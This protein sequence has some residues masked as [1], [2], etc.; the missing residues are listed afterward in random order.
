MEYQTLLRG[1]AWRG[2]GACVCVVF[3]VTEKSAPDEHFPPLRRKIFRYN[4]CVQR[5]IGY[6]LARSCYRHRWWQR[7]ATAASLP[8]FARTDN[9]KLFIC[10]GGPRSEKCPRFMTEKKTYRVGYAIRIT[11]QVFLAGGRSSLCSCTAAAAAAQ[12]GE[13]KRQT[14][15]P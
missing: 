15:Q 4:A 10:L 12:G 1:S 6:L 14:L 11:Q 2:D 9:T 7:V 8:R 5:G 13:M 3:P